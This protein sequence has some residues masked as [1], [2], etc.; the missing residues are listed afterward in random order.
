MSKFKTFVNRYG[1]ILFFVGGF[2]F[3]TFTMVRIDSVLDLIWQFGYLTI[4]TTLI[5]ARVRQEQGVWTP[6]GLL[7]RVWHHETEALHFCYGGLLSGYVIFYFKSTSVSRSFVFLTLIAV[8]MIANEMPQVKR[9]GSRMR[10]GLYAFCVVSYLNYLLPDIIGRMGW[11]TF[12]IAWLLTVMITYRMI[13]VV[14]RYAEDP[15][16]ATR[17]L[18]V[19]PAVVLA[20]VMFLYAFKLIPPVPLSLRTL[21]VC[22]NVERVGDRYHLY[23][24][25]P[26]W[27]KFWKTDNV[28]FP[29]RDGEP[30]IT[31]MAVF[32]PKRFSHQLMIHWSKKD[33][34]SGKWI[35]SDRVP[36]A[37]TGG[38]GNGYR[39]VIRK[40]H[41]EA[42]RWRVQVETE[43]ERV[44][45]SEDFTIV[46]DA[47]TEPRPLTDRWM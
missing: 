16:R 10:L 3:D 35:T 17:L 1:N 19:S 43:D 6:T 25:K 13:K 4:I 36:M 29:A 28:E 46:P 5:I 45:G 21:T 39:G 23:L 26:P 18:S 44:L 30:L 37:M 47:S 9:L 20:L 15:V 40:E 38:R 8:L 7:A 27:Y 34:R 33:E 12:S 11:G 2:I 32:G 14:A 41:Y 22:R 31:F 24:R 42:G